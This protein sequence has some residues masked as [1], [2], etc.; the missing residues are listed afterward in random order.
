MCIRDRT[1]CQVRVRVRPQAHDRPDPGP[2]IRVRADRHRRRQEQR[3]QARRQQPEGLQVA[4]LPA[5][6]QPGRKARPGRPRCGGRCRQHRDGLR[7]RSTARARREGRDGDLPAQP[8]RDPGL[9]R[10]IRRS[11]RRRREVPLPDQ[12][13]AL[14]RRWQPELPRDGTGRARREG[15][16]SAA[17]HRPDRQPEDGCADH[18]RR[19]AGRHRCAEGHGCRCV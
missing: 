18:G 19:R 11:R 12:P 17:G 7:P 9:P 4:E 5:S 13:R 15:P 16:P 2:G 14:R 1:R 10:G 6:L 8:G 3:R